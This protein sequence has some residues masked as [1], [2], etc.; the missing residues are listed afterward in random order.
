MNWEQLKKDGFFILKSIGDFNNGRKSQDYTEY[1]LI[2]EVSNTERILK[3]YLNS[4]AAKEAQKRFRF[5][6]KEQRHVRW[7]SSPTSL[8][9]SAEKE[10][11]IIHFH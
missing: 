7:V 6:I 3:C 2:K 1:S 8:P 11:M 5:D 10:P 9:I 4:S